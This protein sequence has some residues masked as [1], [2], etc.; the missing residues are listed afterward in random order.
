MMLSY[1][2]SAARRFVMD[3]LNERPGALL[4]TNKALWFYADPIVAQSRVLDV[5]FLVGS[6]EQC[7]VLAGKYLSGPADIVAFTVDGASVDEGA[8]ALTLPPGMDCF[9]RLPEL[10]LIRRFP[11]ERLTVLDARVPAGMRVTL[12]AD[13]GSQSAGSLLRTNVREK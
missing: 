7:E 1:E 5:T 6:S 2:F 9:E 3:L 10:N 8:P 4:L 12:G 11:A 13:T